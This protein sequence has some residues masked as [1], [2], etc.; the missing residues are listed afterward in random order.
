MRFRGDVFAVAKDK[1]AAMWLV[2][3][4][5]R[6]AAVCWRVTLDAESR[7]VVQMLDLIVLKVNIF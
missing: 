4:L 6:K 5:A 7:C 3:E 1:K 2:S